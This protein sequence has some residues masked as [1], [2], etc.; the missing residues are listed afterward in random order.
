[1]TMN[2]LSLA[3]EQAIAAWKAF[4]AAMSKKKPAKVKG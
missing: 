3:Y 1:M 2:A 4:E